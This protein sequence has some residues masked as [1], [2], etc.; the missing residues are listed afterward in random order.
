MWECCLR[1]YI[2]IFLY[3]YLYVGM[4]FINIYTYVCIES[5]VGKSATPVGVVSK[6]VW[7]LY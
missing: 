3:I 6:Y 4:L 7:P 1:I 2:Y 5:Y